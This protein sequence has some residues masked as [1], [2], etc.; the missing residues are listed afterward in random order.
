MQDTIRNLNNTCIKL[1]AFEKKIP[2]CLH[3]CDLTHS[4]R[5]KDLFNFVENS[6]IPV[7]S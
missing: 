4:K 7:A 2:N 6:L 3:G 1:W 5:K